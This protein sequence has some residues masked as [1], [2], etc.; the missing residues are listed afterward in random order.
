MGP[1]EGLALDPTAR[2]DLCRQFVIAQG[3]T[4]VKNG[5]G[6]NPF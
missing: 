2:Q 3:G 6:T 5:G 4:A 1:F